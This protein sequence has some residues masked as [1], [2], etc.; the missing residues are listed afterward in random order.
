MRRNN[1]PSQES[2]SSLDEERRGSKTGAAMAARNR[3]RLPTDF[4]PSEE[5]AHVFRVRRTPK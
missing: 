5:P 1:D 3:Q 2:P 4:L